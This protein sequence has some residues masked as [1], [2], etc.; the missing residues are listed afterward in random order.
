MTA[1]RRSR[2]ARWRLG[3]LLA[4][5]LGGC[6]DDPEVRGWN[7]EQPAPSASAAPETP[8]DRLAPGEL[9]PG[10]LEVFGFPVPREMELKH[11]FPDT[12]YI[13]GRVRAEDVSNYVR[14]HVVVAHVEVGAARTVFPRARIKGDPKKRV[15]RLDV[16]AVGPRTKL[17]IRDVT[18]SP[19]PRGLSQKER[20]ERAGFS[21][22]GELLNEKQRE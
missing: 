22:Q 7:D 16:V 20:W 18:K 11:R 10:E 5:G 4:V 6:E 19:A 12:V 15:F 3:A 14:K 1:R 9:A 17:V 8:V 2:H 13:Q 21:A